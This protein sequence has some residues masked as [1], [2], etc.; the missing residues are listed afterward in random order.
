MEIHS[1][2]EFPL[3]QDEPVPAIRQFAQLLRDGAVDTDRAEVD[4]NLVATSTRGR[5]T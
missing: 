2:A 3:E 5:T 4:L 1:F